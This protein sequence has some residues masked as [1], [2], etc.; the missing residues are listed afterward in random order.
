MAQR[1]GFVVLPATVISLR[2]R[3]GGFKR[4]PLPIV[5]AAARMTR[6]GRRGADFSLRAP[7]RIQGRIISDV[8]RLGPQTK[9]SRSVPSGAG[10]QDCDFGE[11]AKSPAVIG[12]PVCQHRDAVAF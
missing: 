1:T 2:N 4:T 5:A 3:L 12:K 6:S 8:L 7:G 11:V 9:K 10:N